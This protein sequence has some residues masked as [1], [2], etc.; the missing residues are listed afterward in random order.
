[1][2][3]MRLFRP[4]FAGFLRTYWRGGVVCLGLMGLTALIG[5]FS[6]QPL[7]LIGYGLL[8]DAVF[9][10]LIACGLFPRYA[11]AQVRLWDALENLPPDTDRLPI[12]RRALEASYRQMALDLSELCQR[13]RGQEERRRRELEDFYTLWVHQIKTPISALDLMLQTP[14]DPDRSRMAQELTKIQQYAQ[15]VLQYLRLESIQE[16]L[17]LKSVEMEPLVRRSVKKLKTLF[18]CSKVSVTIGDC[19][20]RVVTD[21]KWLDLILE[22]VLTNAVKYTPA[23]GRVTIQWEGDHTLCIRDTG[24]GIRE[25]DIPR[26]FQRGFTGHNGR[27]EDRSTGIGLYLSREAARRL[28]HT[29]RIESRVGRGTAVFIGLGRDQLEIF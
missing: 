24:I 15:M 1:M 26:V 23:G 25:E 9:L 22:Q 20:G 5:V 18:I 29:M 8:L 2:K 21:E 27:V 16:D 14:G 11:A 6:R 19:S 7:D 13:E 12:P 3:Y 10:L 4:L 17:D 28:Q